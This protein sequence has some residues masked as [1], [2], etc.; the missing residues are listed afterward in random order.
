MLG[1][2]SEG[3]TISADNISHIQVIKGLPV[4]GG[5]IMK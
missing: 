4:S 5:Q 3:D 2:S 1:K